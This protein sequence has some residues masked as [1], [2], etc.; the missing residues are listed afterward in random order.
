MTAC[1]SSTSELLQKSMYFPNCLWSSHQ[2][3][4]KI[5]ITAEQATEEYFPQNIGQKQLIKSLDKIKYESY[6]SFVKKKRNI[7]TASKISITFLKFVRQSTF[8]FY[9]RDSAV[10]VRGE[11]P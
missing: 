2:Y 5:L 7:R 9:G 1:L 11:K 4:N 3:D 8:I 6:K 10:Q